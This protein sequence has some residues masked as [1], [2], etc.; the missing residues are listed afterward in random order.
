MYSFSAGSSGGLMNC[1]PKDLHKF[2]CDYEDTEGDDAERGRCLDKIEKLAWLGQT[3]CLNSP[4]INN[5]GNR[6]MNCAQLNGASAYFNYGWGG[7]SKHEDGAKEFYW[8]E[9]IEMQSSG[10]HYF[11]STRNDDF[12]NR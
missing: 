5:A 10:E 11:K 3:K 9:P 8:G 12:S 2:F 7:S 6:G 4:E 1:E